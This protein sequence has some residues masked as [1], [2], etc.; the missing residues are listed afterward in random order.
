MKLGQSNFSASEWS[1]N[2]LLIHCGVG[3]DQNRFESDH[4]DNGKQ[5]CLVDHVNVPICAS[6]TSELCLAVGAT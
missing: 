5:C 3:N 1:R 2:K 4:W 6:S